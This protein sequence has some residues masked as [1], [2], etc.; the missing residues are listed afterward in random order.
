[1]SRWVPLRAQLSRVEAAIEAAALRSAGF[2]VWEPD[3][4]WS[5]IE[6][7]L[8][9]SLEFGHR[10]YVLEPHREDARAWLNALRSDEKPEPLHPCPVCGGKTRR[11]R[12]VIVILIFWWFIWGLFPFYRRRRICVDC[13]H[14]HTPGRPE[15]FVKSELGWTP[16]GSFGDSF[17]SFLAWTRSIGYDTHPETELTEQDDEPRRRV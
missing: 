15:P 14:R 17:R 7:P 4:I 8:G 5:A 3:R 1:M 16:P 9:D 2:P 13:G 10:M 11:L 6:P 12:R